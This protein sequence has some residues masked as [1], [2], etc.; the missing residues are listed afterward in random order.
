MLINIK[1]V[2]QTWSSPL[3][4]SPLQFIVDSQLPRTT[5]FSTG[6]RAAW[7]KYRGGTSNLAPHFC[8]SCNWMHKWGDH[9]N[10]ERKSRR[11]QV[12]AKTER[13]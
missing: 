1:T 12:E 9:D 6:R 11:S 5:P 3:G 4:P 10:A 2:S 13:P 7:M 8:L